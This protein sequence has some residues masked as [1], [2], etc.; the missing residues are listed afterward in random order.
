MRPEPPPKAPHGPDL[1]PVGEDR[2]RRVQVEEVVLAQPEAAA[3]AARPL[4]VLDQREAVDADRVVELGLL[5][6]RVLGVLAVRLD[7][8]GAV[9]RGAAAVAARERVVEARVLAGGDVERAEAGL[10]HHP[11]RPGR[12]PV[13]E[14]R[15]E[16]A[17]DH[18]DQA[19]VGLP[20]ADDRSRPA[21]SSRRCRRALAG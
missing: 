20:A 2:E 1:V 6:R 15:Q 19:R 16:R 11:L 14:G 9:A 4:G 21:C 10:A 5:D 3:E 12:Q 7:G 17:D 18:L 8:V 13:G